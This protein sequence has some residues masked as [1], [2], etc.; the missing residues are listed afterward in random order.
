MNKLY[1]GLGLA[2]LGTAASAS[3][4]GLEELT[5]VGS[6]ED[7]RALPGTGSVIDSEQ[8]LIEAASDIN[9]LL[10]TVPGVYVLE[11]DGYGLRPNIGI[12]GATSER[13]SK[14]TLLED[15]VMIAP[16]PYSNPAAY[17]FPTTLRMHQVD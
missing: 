13:S 2:L 10:K 15:G 7:A 5:I 4:T 1:V 14:V 16:A 3:D 17:Y 9:K 8:I 11:E 12:R 6:R